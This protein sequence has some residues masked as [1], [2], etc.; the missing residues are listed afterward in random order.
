VKQRKNNYPDIQRV[1]RE[2]IAAA[3]VKRILSNCCG[4]TWNGPSPRL[5]NAWRNAFSVSQFLKDCQAAETEPHAGVGLGTDHRIGSKKT[6]GFALTLDDYLLH[7]CIFAKQKSE[8]P[9]GPASR[10]R[11]FSARRNH[12]L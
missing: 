4:A 9:H 5:S 3:G 2:A 1:P 8:E 7:L 10:M 6:T 12:R 11:R